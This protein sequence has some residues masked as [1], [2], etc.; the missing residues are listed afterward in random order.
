MKNRR[1]WIGLGVAIFLSLIIGLNIYRN[2]GETR[3][4]VQVFKVT[5][6][7]IEENI[8]ASGKVESAE[9][10]EIVSRT[11]AIVQDIFVREGDSVKEGQVIM[12]LDTA[13]LTHNLKREEANLAVQK[14]NLA[15][16]GAGARPQELAQYRAEVDRTKVIFDS[17]KAKYERSKNLFEEGAIS[18]ENLE[19]A[20]VEYVTAEAGY[21]SAQQKLSLGREGDTEENIRA[22]QAQVLQAE[23]AVE[24]AREQL[25]EAE[26][27]APMKGVIL[28][29]DAEKGRYITTGTILAV[30]GNPDKMQV[31]ADVSESD[32]GDLAVGQ[33]VK[34]TCPAIFG[35]EFTGKVTRVGVAAITKEKSSG[36]Q[37]D[38]RVTVSI[39][40]FDRQLKQ[41]YSVDLIITTASKPR[42]LAIPHEAVIEKNKIEEVFVIEKDRVAK[43]RVKTGIGNELYITIEKGLTT[44][45]KIV[46]NPPDKLK[47]G[48]L[49]KET[50]YETIKPVLTGD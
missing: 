25:A 11:S 48:S 35:A 3:I 49:V 45:D 39:N 40:G 23:T 10:E 12:R 18:K 47:T 24:L 50:P 5:Q 13:E 41:G 27:K 44:G 16:A 46:V 30:V 26:I 29:L 14:A 37:T 7:K 43:R 38:V 8:L 20:Y 17:A 34:I 2:T 33:P 4:P 21:S 36:E 31:K 1:L 19:A 28:S 32:G 15:K 42:A 9:K 22:L 6:E